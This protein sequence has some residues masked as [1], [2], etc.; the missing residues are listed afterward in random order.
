MKRNI[1]LKLMYN[2]TAYHGWQVQKRDITVGQ[3]LEQ[4]GRDA[5]YGF[6]E[7]ARRYFG[8]DVIAVAHHMDD[9]AETLLLH[10]ARGAG[11]RGLTGMRPKRGR[12][13]RCLRSGAAKLKRTFCRRGLPSARMKRTCFGRARA[14]GSGWMCCL[15]LPNM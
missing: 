7:E 13:A 8:A 14:T 10:L 1:A 15:T 5:R 11:L 6:L 4:A 12:S 9:Q 3:T 2:G